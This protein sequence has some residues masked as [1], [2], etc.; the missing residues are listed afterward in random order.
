MQISVIVPTHNRR[1]LLLR[2]LDSLLRQTLCA[3]DYEVIVVCDGA[4]DG[5]AEQV[6]TL[7]REH[8]R[9]HLVEQPQRGPAV[10]RNAGARIAQGRYLAFTDDD[11]IVSRE[12]LEKLIESLKES[13]IVGSMGRT[14]TIVSEITPLTHQMVSDHSSIFVMATCN[15]A[16]RR[17]AFEQLRGFDEGFQFP[18][19]EDADFAWRLE[20]LGKVSYAPDALVVHPPRPETFT[21]KALWVRF[22]ESEFLL[23]S[24]NPNAYRKHRSPSPWSTIYW[25][26]FVVSQFQSAKSALRYIFFRFR[27]DYFAI[28]IALII[29]RWWILILLFPRFLRAARRVR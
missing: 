22:F 18:H 10:A 29:A 7:C 4:T 28:A 27:P 20:S 23:F 9:L 19:N 13:G 21:N 25:K 17:D 26:V 3:D 12:W 16:Y 11:C 24:K 2:L 1:V 5:T 14:T 8:S 15:A 6:R